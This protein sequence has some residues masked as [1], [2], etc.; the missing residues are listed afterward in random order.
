MKPNPTHLSAVDQ[1]LTIRLDLSLFLNLLLELRSE[2]R[3]G[4]D[5]GQL[6][7]RRALDVSVKSDAGAASA[8]CKGDCLTG[9]L[10]L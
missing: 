8:S 6:E 10:A 4:H 9:G 2:E 1:S 3:E 5:E 7:L